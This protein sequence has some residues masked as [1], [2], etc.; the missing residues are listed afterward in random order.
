[1]YL[2]TVVVPLGTVGQHSQRGGHSVHPLDKCMEKSH[3][4]PQIG[5]EGP[6]MT[7]AGPRVVMGGLHPTLPGTLGSNETTEC[8]KLLQRSM[9]SPQQFITQ[10]RCM[11]QRRSSCQGRLR[12]DSIQSNHPSER[13]HRLSSFLLL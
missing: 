10:L 6:E 3:I 2:P 13:K 4:T 7:G 12:R 8:L 11:K 5:P 1:M 9:G